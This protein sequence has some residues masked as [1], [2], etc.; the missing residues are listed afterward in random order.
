[1]T[2]KCQ[3]A[4]EQTIEALFHFILFCSGMF[5][6]PKLCSEL[7]EWEEIRLVKS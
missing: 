3:S 6:M 2:L 1:M 4:Q 5:Y 7:G